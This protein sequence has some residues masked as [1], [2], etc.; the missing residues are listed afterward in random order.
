M[1]ARP[2]TPE[3]AQLGSPL[4]ELHRTTQQHGGKTQSSPSLGSTALTDAV[5]QR[6]QGDTSLLLCYLLL[7]LKVIQDKLKQ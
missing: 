3:T 7:P 6:P 2:S 1:L 5:I 4:P